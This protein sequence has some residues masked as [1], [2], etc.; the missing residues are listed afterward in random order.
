MRLAQDARF[1]R[2]EHPGHR[3]RDGELPDETRRTV[4]PGKTRI[5]GAMSRSARVSA[6]FLRE[7]LGHRPTQSG[8][9]PL[10]DIQLVL[11]KLGDVRPVAE[12]LARTSGGV[13]ATQSV[14]LKVPNSENAPSSKT[15]TK[16]AGSRARGTDM[17]PMP[18]RKVPHIAVPEV[19][20]LEVPG[21]DDDRG[22]DLAG[23]DERPLRR[24][25]VPVQRRPPGSRRMETPAIP[26]ERGSSS[27]VAS[28][29]EPPSS[30]LP[31]PRLHLEAKVRQLLVPAVL[32][33]L[34]H[35]L[36][37]PRGQKPARRNHCSAQYPSPRHIRHC[38]SIDYESVRRNPVPY[39]MRP[40]V[41][42]NLTGFPPDR[43]DWKSI[44]PRC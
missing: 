1:E 35:R 21:W 15:S 12:C 39:A 43:T 2:R 26:L 14:T 8:H 20:G 10:E 37:R 30:T 16:W 17:L 23:D 5:A 22:V 27:T 18:A 13:W 42:S 34:L 24:D 25:G 9:R 4:P 40:S 41:F 11:R 28:L 38:C 33:L 19:V 36:G 3:R 32:L 31:E 29:A 6:V 7:P 44:L